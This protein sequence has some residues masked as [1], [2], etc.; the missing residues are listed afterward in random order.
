MEDELHLSYPTL[1]NRL[2]EVIRA[3]GYEPN[4]EESQP[5]M[6]TEERNHIMDELAEGK[7]TFDQAKRLLSG[8]GSAEE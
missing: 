3:L 7:I 2:I 8:E 1:R 5:R 6:T 4:K